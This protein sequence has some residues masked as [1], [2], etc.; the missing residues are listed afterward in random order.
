MGERGPRAVPLADRFWPKVDKSGGPEACWPW[1][2]CVNRVDQCGW[3]WGGPG[4]PMQ[5]AHRVAWELA[6]GPIPA[7]HVIARTC[8][9]KLC[10]NP[11]HMVCKP[12]K[13]AA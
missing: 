6:H 1:T 8:D 9:T 3:M 2:G 4:R 13:A 11:A 10:V 12:R 7:G 5:R